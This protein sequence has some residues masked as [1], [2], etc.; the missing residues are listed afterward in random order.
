MRELTVSM[1][2]RTGMFKTEKP[3]LSEPT[4]PIIEVFA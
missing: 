2:G 3:R 4:V 1:Q